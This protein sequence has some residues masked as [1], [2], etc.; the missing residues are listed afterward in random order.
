MATEFKPQAYCTLSNHGGMQIEIDKNFETV[1]YKYYDNKVSRRVKLQFKANGDI[2]FRAMNRVWYLR[3][4][5][6]L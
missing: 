3:D 4:F 5:M 2:C 6:R 1:R